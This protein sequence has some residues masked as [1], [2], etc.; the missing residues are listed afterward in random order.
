MGKQERKHE[1]KKKKEKQIRRERYSR[2]IVQGSIL[3]F[4]TRGFSINHIVGTFDLVVF[5]IIY[6]VIPNTSPEMTCNFKMAGR[7]VKLSII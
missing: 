6:G 2:F 7:R 4:G 1:K 3:K 5:S